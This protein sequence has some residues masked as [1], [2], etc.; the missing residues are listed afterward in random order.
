MKNSIVILF[1]FLFGILVTTNT[2]AQSKSVHVRSYHTKSGKQVKSHN[3]RPPK[4]HK[5]SLSF[6]QADNL[7]MLYRRRLHSEDYFPVS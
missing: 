6:L 3:R 2:H 4:H 1:V 5:H 7:A